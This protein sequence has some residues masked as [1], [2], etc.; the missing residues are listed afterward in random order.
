[1]AAD[2][3]SQTHDNSLNSSIGRRFSFVSVPL[4]RVLELGSKNQI[5]KLT[6]LWL[7]GLR[8]IKR[9]VGKKVWG[10]RANI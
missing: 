4:L 2:E 5:L 3:F 1:M 7:A 9:N 10:V 6:I 8:F